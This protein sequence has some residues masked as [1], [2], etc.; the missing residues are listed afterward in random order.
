MKQFA[1][2]FSFNSLAS[3]SLASNLTG[4]L[5]TKFI[6]FQQNSLAYNSLASNSL[7]SNKIHWFPTNFYV[8][9]SVSNSIII[10][11]SVSLDKNSF[12]SSMGIHLIVDETSG[13]STVIN[14]L[15]SSFHPGIFEVS[16]TSCFKFL[17]TFSISHP[18]S[19]KFR[20]GIACH[21][22]SLHVNPHAAASDVWALTIKCCAIILSNC[23]LGKTWLGK[24]TGLGKT[25]LGKIGL[26]KIGSYIYEFSKM[27]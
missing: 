10:G 25:E 8:F 18:C 12:R 19:N 1:E 26:G 24:K 20:I 3:N 7:A 16:G 14:E 11:I 22:T 5:P 9:Y 17:I 23:W 21:F 2:N 4:L 13:L 15:S 27:L 6:G